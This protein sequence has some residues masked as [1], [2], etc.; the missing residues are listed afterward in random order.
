MARDFKL[1]ELG[2]NIVSAK[3]VAVLVSPGDEVEKEQGLIEVETDKATV[4]VPSPQAGR[5]GEV[6]VAE[7]DTIEVGA[8]LVSF[9][10]PDEGAREEEPKGEQERGEE[11]EG[12]PRG[13]RKAR[14]KERR[15]APSEERGEARGKPARAERRAAEPEPEAAG[16]AGEAEEGEEEERSE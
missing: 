7:G 15:A 11:D 9:A 14:A 4:E 8:A 16:E 3:V 6:H 13:E 12:E 5:I 10:E 1:P 2:E